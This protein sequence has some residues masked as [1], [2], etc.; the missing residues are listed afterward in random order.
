MLWVR[1]CCAALFLGALGLGASCAPPNLYAEYA[2]A[3]GAPRESV[4][5]YDDCT[6]SSRASFR[7][8]C[9]ARCGG[10]VATTTDRPCERLG[11]ERCT[12]QAL[13]PSEAPHDEFEEESE[14]SEAD[15]AVGVFGAL[16]DV[17]V[18]AAEVSDSHR[19]R[20]EHVAPP[21]DPPKPAPRARV[22]ARPR[23]PV[24]EGS[25]H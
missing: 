10:V 20:H 4:S 1:R 12:W 3:E 13:A 25:R 19:H 18:F 7:E 8:A 2:L 11:Q 5:C 24:S 6:R 22:P 17:F 15:V 21:P 14:V 16:L 23:R 9:F